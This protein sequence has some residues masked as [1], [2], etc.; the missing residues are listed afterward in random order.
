MP[1]RT[2]PG[3]SGKAVV[4]AAVRVA[5]TGGLGAV[6]M[7]G[8]G[9]ELGVEAMSLYHH[10]RNKEH[11]LDDLADWIFEQVELPLPAEGWR[12]G[13]ER[14]AGS[15]RR[16]LGAHPWALGLVESRRSPGPGLLRHHDAVLGC[17]RGGGFSVRLAAH[18]FAAIDAYVFGFVLTEQTLPM[19]PGESAGDFAATLDLPAET[20]PHLVE[21]V[22]ELTSCEDYAFAE[23]FDYGL[24]LVHDGLAARLDDE[25]GHR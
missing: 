15:M 13:M 5:D 23:E 14:R 19:E 21:N 12:P 7:R 20:Y 6:S 2:R 16:V 18:A 9:R 8:V 22:V 17:L 1:G 4:E 25:L 3:L 10:V 24:A 11:L